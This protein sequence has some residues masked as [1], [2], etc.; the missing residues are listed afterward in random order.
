MAQPSTADDQTGT[1]SSQRTPALLAPDQRLFS[2]E[3]DLKPWP[4]KNTAE[5]KEQERRDAAREKKMK[6]MMQI[7]K[8]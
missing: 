7:C 3:E 1:S 8:C 2:H 5:A 6:E 4:E